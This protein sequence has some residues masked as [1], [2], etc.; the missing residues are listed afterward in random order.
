MLDNVTFPSLL[1]FIDNQYCYPFF[2]ASIYIPYRCVLLYKAIC[3]FSTFPF[4]LKK[5]GRLS[6]ARG[7][8][9]L[10]V[11]ARHTLSGLLDHD[12]VR[13]KFMQFDS[14]GYVGFYIYSMTDFWPVA[15]AKYLIYF[16]Q[17]LEWDQ[18][19]ISNTA[20]DMI[21][22]MPNPRRV[23]YLDREGKM[24]P[25]TPLFLISTLAVWC[26]VLWRC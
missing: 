16:Y 19:H 12:L 21:Q 1:T 22:D 6:R 24:S 13:G 26:S 17:D 20:P 3:S 9:I 10:T 7:R 4:I 2:W 11:D 8:L 14:C 15:S 5:I 23:T 25:N 18:W